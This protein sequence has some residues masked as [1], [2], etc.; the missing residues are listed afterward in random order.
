MKISSF[1]VTRMMPNSML[2]LTDTSNWLMRGVNSVSGATSG[3]LIDATPL[4]AIVGATSAP[5]VHGPVQLAA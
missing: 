4:A 3:T 2:L 1:G 5:G